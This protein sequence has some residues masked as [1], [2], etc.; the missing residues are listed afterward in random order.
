MNRYIKTFL[1]LAI[2]T[3]ISSLGI[4]PASAA[5]LSNTPTFTLTGTT[6]AL[7]AG[8][9]VW[10]GGTTV[11]QF[12]ACQNPTIP[13]DAGVVLTDFSTIPA[14][15]L[16]LTADM[17]NANPFLGGDLLGAYFS[18]LMPYVNSIASRPHIHVI[19]KNTDAGVEKYAYSESAQLT[20]PSPTFSG[21]WELTV[22]GNTASWTDVSW[23]NGT[24]AGVQLWACDGPVTE[25]LT[26]ATTLS[27]PSG[28]ASI[29][30]RLQVMGGASSLNLSTATLSS[31]PVPYDPQ[32]GDYLVA[33]STVSSTVGQ[34][35]YYIHSDSEQY[36]PGSAA[37]SDIRAGP[38]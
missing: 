25:S 5:T 2:S 17:Q 34:T 36:V 15:C 12:Y 31:P 28:S 11:N 10:S 20:V 32:I 35:T 26:P 27:I 13:S 4:L 24:S 19:S 7:D 22:S 1:A 30:T 38:S 37:S 9:G 16:A 18:P 6:V 29:C 21:P 14:T 23:S 8:T 33:V 3:S